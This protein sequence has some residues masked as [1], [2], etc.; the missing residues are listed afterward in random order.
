MKST[1]QSQCL[2][3]RALGVKRPCCEKVSRKMALPKAILWNGSLCLLFLTH[4]V[5]V[6]CGSAEQNL[7]KNESE[8]LKRTNLK[9]V[10]ISMASPR[11]ISPRPVSCCNEVFRLSMFRE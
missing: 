5:Y 8:T 4:C 2:A 11:K 9:K 6:Y 3:L 7:R 1:D 10:G